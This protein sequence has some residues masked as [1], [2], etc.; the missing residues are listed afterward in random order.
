MP[1]TVRAHPKRICGS[2]VRRTNWLRLPFGLP[3]L[4]FEPPIPPRPGLFE[5]AALLGVKRGAGLG[6]WLQRPK[7]HRSAQFVHMLT[8][9]Q[10]AGTDAPVLGRIH[11]LGSESLRTALAPGD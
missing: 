8:V 10:L 6:S 7:A 9:G 4:A 1:A 11:P 5:F 2:D 3:A